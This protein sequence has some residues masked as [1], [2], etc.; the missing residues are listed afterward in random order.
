MTSKLQEGILVGCG[1]PLLDISAPVPLQFLEGY[2]MNVDDAILAEERHMPIYREL[3]DGY[4]AEY[5]A[6]GSVQNSL[7]IA[8]WILRQPNVAVFFGCVGQDDYA[9]IL[10]E[11]AR[12]AGVDAH[13]QVSPD[14]P[15][16]TCAVLITGTHR[17]LCANLA[18]ANKFTI[19]HLEQPA[20]KALIDNAQYYYISGFFLTVNPPSIMRVAATANAKQRPF[21]MNLSAPFISQYFMEPLMAV[22]PYVDI[23]F[24]N[25]AEAHAFATA[26]GW[27]AD[28]DLREIG[29]RL[30]ALPK[31]N[32]ERPRIAILTQGCDPVL[33]I[34]HDK[35]QEFPVTRLA[36]HEIVDTNGAGD[37]FVGGFLSQYVQG[38]SLDVCIRCG[39]YAAGHIIKNPGC[40]YSGEPEFN[41]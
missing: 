36:V 23:I 12:A 32:S 25:E 20:N 7:R 5:L 38:K 26:Q 6:G 2:G 29:K 41:E 35:V 1:N 4:Q 27:P 14:T 3:V 15:T 39:N 28:A 34:Q 8:Q 21:L 13:Y 31:I 9:D 18:A 24:G 37:A 22:M 11:K 33:L 40:T 19:D 16:G 30:V 10:R 17:S